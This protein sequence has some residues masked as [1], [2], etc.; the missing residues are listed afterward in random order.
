MKKFLK[1]SAWGLAAIV[2][3]ALAAWFWADQVATSR[4]E[5]QWTVHKADFPIPFPLRDDELEALRV[6]RILAGAPATDPL[7]TRAL[8]TSRWRR[9]SASLRGT[10]TGWK[11]HIRQPI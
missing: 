4:Y 5:K 9:S 10:R 3:L 1:Y 8:P 7:M 6:E 2:V 11:S